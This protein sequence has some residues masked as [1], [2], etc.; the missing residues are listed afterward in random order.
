MVSCVGLSLGRKW[1]LWEYLKCAV[2]HEQSEGRPSS[3]GNLYIFENIIHINRY[4]NST[5]LWTECT[6]YCNCSMLYC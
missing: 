1:K 5:A 3:L 2:L 4:L 6:W